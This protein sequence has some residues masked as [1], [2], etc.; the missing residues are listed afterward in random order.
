MIAPSYRTDRIV[1]D[2]LRRM[3]AMRTLP[4]FLWTGI[5]LGL[6]IG[7]LFL[8][9]AARAIAPALTVD[10][11]G[12][13]LLVGE[14]DVQT[15][16]AA[17]SYRGYYYRRAN[18][19]VYR[20]DP[21]SGARV[22]LSNGPGTDHHPTFSPDGCCV[23]FQS[24]R[25]GHWEIY[26]ADQRGAPAVNLTHRSENDTAPAWSPDGTRIAFIAMDA[27]S[28]VV[29]SLLDV[30]SGQIQP[31][32]PSD[33]VLLAPPVWAPDSRRIAFVA[34]QFNS[35]RLISGLYVIDAETAALTIVG[36]HEGMLGIPSWSPDGTRL[37][38]TSLE[39]GALYIAG[40]DAPP[41][42]LLSGDA[43][44][45]FISLRYQ[46]LRPAWSPDGTRVAF[47]AHAGAPYDFDLFVMNVDGSGLYNLT[48]SPGNDANPAWS[49]DGTRIAFQSWRDGNAEIYIMAT[50]GS[51]QR[52]VTDTPGDDWEPV[53]IT[54]SPRPG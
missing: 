18:V 14:Q 17:L 20:V 1:G 42:I 5:A 12:Q 47:Q 38:Y 27:A 40:E 53:W 26:V 32:S 33:L 29:L 4:K 51:D 2:P 16:S 46:D 35:G 13:L 6:A 52:R 54:T 11:R 7:L 10:P 30:H 23:A 22:N 3:E 25:S 8:M 49:P 41:Q 44:G 28:S 15:V 37:V 45:K 19:E 9:G 21:I 43:G 39:E 31:L 36:T 48:R 50:D 34:N 24:D